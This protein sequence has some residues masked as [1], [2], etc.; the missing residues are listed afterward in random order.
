VSTLCVAGWGVEAELLARSG[1]EA[2]INLLYITQKDCEERATLYSEF[3]HMLAESYATRVDQWPDLF[4]GLGLDLEERRREIKENWERVKRNYP[5]KDFWASKL[6]KNGRL[7]EMAKQ[8]GLQ[9]YYDF[10]YWFASNHSH[11]NV[12][13]AVDI[14]RVSRD[15]KFHFN[16]GPSDIAAQYTLLHATDFLL[17]AYQCFVGFFKLPEENNVND[18]I[19]KFSAIYKD[20]RVT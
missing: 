13:S 9:W 6:I 4:K 10:L 1:L 20:I 2:L 12:R 11:A 5:M 15:G 14:M 3:D 17:R 18:L 8:V 16:L 19:A 7:R